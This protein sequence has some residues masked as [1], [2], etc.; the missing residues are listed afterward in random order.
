M[1]TLKNKKAGFTL[2]ELMIVVVIIG[3]LAALAIPAFVGYIRRSKTAEATTN[4]RNLF[5]GAA[6]YYQQENFTSAMVVRAGAATASVACTVAPQNTPNAPTVAKTQVV[7]GGLMSFS[8]IGFSVGDPI[9]YQYQ[10]TMS[11]DMCGNLVGMDFYEFNALGNLDGDGITSTFAL[12]AGS[13]GDNNLIRSP[14]FYITNE[15]E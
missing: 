14:G 10:I 5:Q 9:Y 3:I 4:V 15:L 8:A 12:G 13:D 11:T 2:I 1:K 7:F 6:A